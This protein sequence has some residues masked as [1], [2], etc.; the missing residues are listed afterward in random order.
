[1]IYPGYIKFSP[2]CKTDFS[3]MYSYSSAKIHVSQKFIQDLKKNE[4]FAKFSLQRCSE[5]LQH[6]NSTETG[7]C[8]LHLEAFSVIK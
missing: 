8:S 1:M 7:K 3:F 4:A 5:L 2:I 6:R